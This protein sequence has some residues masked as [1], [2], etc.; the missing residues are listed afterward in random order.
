MTHNQKVWAQHEEKQKI[1]MGKRRERV[2][3]W[4]FFLLACYSLF[5]LLISCCHPYLF[6]SR[7][8]S[9]DNILAVNGILNSTLPNA[10]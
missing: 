5:P 8:G 9:T 2:R 7:T 4:H 10:T 6:S 1:K 3:R